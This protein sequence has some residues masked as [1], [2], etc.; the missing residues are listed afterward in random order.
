MVVKQILMIKGSGKLFQY[1]KIPKIEKAKIKISDFKY[2][3]RIK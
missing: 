1:T 3:T 2:W